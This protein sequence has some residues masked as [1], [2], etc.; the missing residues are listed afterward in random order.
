MFFLS[1]EILRRSVRR[2]NAEGDMG[3]SDIGNTAQRT[4]WSMQAWSSLPPLLKQ[5]I[6]ELPEVSGGTIGIPG[7]RCKLLKLTMLDIRLTISVSLQIKILLSTF[8]NIPLPSMCLC[9]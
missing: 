9:F 4:C 1:T 3:E 2:F 8:N 7:F 6:R 5:K